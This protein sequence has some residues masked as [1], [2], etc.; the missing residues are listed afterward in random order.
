MKS[1]EELREYLTKNL[2]T[3]NKLTS[4]QE[5]IA[6]YSGEDWKQHVEFNSDQ[7]N[8]INYFTNDEFEIYI[9][10]WKSGQEAPIHD[11]PPQG[12]VLKMLQGELE[13]DTC[14]TN[15]LKV[16]NTTKLT[17]SDNSYI[18]NDIG[19]H[20]VRNLGSDAV[21]LHIYAPSRYEQTK[22]NVE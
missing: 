8:R 19:Y 12:C 15:S 17:C 10:C 20:R 5:T 22:F 11:H 9:L 3:N 18:D 16:I 4:L 7:I 2:N 6:S 21:S 1:L 14:C 13:E